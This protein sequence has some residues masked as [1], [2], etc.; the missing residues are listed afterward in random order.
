MTASSNKSSPY[1]RFIPREEVQD[2][3]VWEF[4]SMDGKPSKSAQMAAARESE[5]A[6]PPQVA[7]PDLENIKKQAFDEGFEQGRVAGAKATRE[8]LDAP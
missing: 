7:A 5:M 6:Q 3:S 2:V 4:Q 1:H 8:A